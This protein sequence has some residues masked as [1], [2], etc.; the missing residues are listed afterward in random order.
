MKKEHDEVTFK[1]L[2]NIFVPKLWLIA[3]VSVICSAVLGL[4]SAFIKKDTYTSYSTM[5]V[6]KS[7]TAANTSDIAIAQEMISI[8]EII[9]RTDEVLNIIISKL[10]V[11]YAKSNIT[12]DFLRSAL[13][14]SDLGNN[15]AFKISFTTGDPKL[16]KLLAE[17][18]EMIIPSEIISRIPNALRLTILESPSDAKQNNKY[19]FRNV[20][21][22]F[23]AGALLSAFFIWI[24]SMF[25]VVIR[26]RKKIEDN[27][28]IP[29]LG[30]LPRHEVAT[31][32]EGK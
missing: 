15:G 22:G 6:F 19:T 14:V 31:A 27:F 16:S 18:A 30:V 9:I 10:P 29:I 12:T 32:R 13:T 21:I 24:I 1:D 2:L 17:I 23:L 20:I 8:Y 26:D 3:I 11:E 5:Y 4:Y 25:D 28:D 7:A